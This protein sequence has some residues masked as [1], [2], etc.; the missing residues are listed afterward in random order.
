LLPDIS[1]PPHRRNQRHPTRGRP[2][3][4]GACLGWFWVVASGGGGA[5]RSAALRQKALD[6]D[7]W[8]CCNCGAHANHAH[9]VVPLICGGQAVLSNLASLCGTCH[10]AV[11]GLNFTHH[12]ELTRAGL[13]AA[14][15]R[16]VQLGGLRAGILKENTKAKAAAAD[17]SEAL[18]PILTSMQAQ[19]K[20]LRAMAEAL[21]AAGTI[22]RTGKP[23]APLAVKRHLLRLGLLEAA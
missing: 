18:R 12:R 21:A 3:P 4:R 7:G 1:L 19:G 15:A 17:R 5:V 11:H 9:H 20:S 16:C 8:R 2:G 10:G 13:A 14:K 22:T 6:R 23:L